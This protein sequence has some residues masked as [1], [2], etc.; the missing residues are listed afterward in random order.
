MQRRL[1]QCHSTNIRCKL[2]K[3]V[4]LNVNFVVKSIFVA[5]VLIPTKISMLQEVAYG[6]IDIITQPKCLWM[7]T[8]NYD[9][10]NVNCAVMSLFVP[11]VLIRKLLPRI[12]EGAY[13]NLG[14]ITTQINADRTCSQFLV[15]GVS[16]QRIN[17]HDVKTSIPLAGYFEGIFETLVTTIHHKL[18]LKEYVC[19]AFRKVKPAPT[20]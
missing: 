2:L 1:L 14:I 18:Q 5:S 4:F 15:N 20:L 12:L 3:S 11:N 9:F 6:K 7:G 8:L 19:H 10:L 13:V 17:L 16:V